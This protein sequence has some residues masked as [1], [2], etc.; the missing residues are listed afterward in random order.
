MQ[1]CIIIYFLATV[2]INF[3]FVC[4]C[5]M[6]KLTQAIKTATFTDSNR[7][8]AVVNE[9]GPMKHRTCSLLVLSRLNLLQI[10]KDML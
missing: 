5:N 7:V 3:Y 4:I 9:R 8:R 10:L 1:K 2:D 6:L